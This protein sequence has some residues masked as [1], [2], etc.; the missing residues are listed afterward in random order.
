MCAFLLF[1][2]HQIYL[3]TTHFHSMCTLFQ[4]YPLRACARASLCSYCGR[5]LLFYC[6]TCHSVMLCILFSIHSF[7]LNFHW[8][9][10][11]SFSFYRC[12]L[13]FCSLSL[14]QNQTHLVDIFEF[15]IQNDHMVVPHLGIEHAS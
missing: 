15:E 13:H 3:Y 9:I 11:S 2:F 5:I 8:M 12:L 14:N 10:L 1:C 4:F 6:C 7:K